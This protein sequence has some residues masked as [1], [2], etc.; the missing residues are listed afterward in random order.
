MVALS[1]T[2]MVV[3]RGLHGTFGIFYVALIET[4]GWSRAATAG[5]VS[6][7]IV[8]EGVAHP[9]VGS[10]TDRLGPRKALMLGGLVLCVGLGLSST[11]SSLWELYL[12]VGVVTALGIAFIGMVPH[13]AMLSR[14]FSKRR[15]IALG[16][17]YAGGGLGIT[18]LV[19]LSQLMIDAWG[20]SMA[21]VGLAV[22]AALFVLL[23]VQL[24]FA[25]AETPETH[26]AE[27]RK[28]ELKRDRD[29]DWTVRRALT[30]PAF[31]LLF[32]ARV[33][34]S[35]GN[36]IVVTHQMAHAVDLG[37]PK[38]FAASIFGLMGVFSIFGRLFFG[39]LADRMKGETVF[40]WVQIVS[41]LGIVALLVLR[42][43]S[44]PLLLYAYAALYGLGQGSRALVLSAISA[45]I[46]LGRSFGAIY[47]YFTLSIGVGGAFGA[48]VGGLIHD[49]TRSYFIAF[50]LSVLLFVVSAAI[51]WPSRNLT[52]GLARSG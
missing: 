15:G 33:L 2:H 18:L 8:T 10:L 44:S 13:V 16:I 29:P 4:F 39:Y 38:L 45:E 3:S 36:Q 14:A 40:A 20:W 46:F 31:W 41:C 32:G 17:A 23:P 22:I 12:W 35:M 47:G 37:F 49:I 19:P 27:K 34:A 26:R 5:A 42:E 48:W 30:S 11:V 24:F 1:F 21:Y 28:Q 6:L 43:G 50:S 9:I 52:R 51:V 25:G 7:L